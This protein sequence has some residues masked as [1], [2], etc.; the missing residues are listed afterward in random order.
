[1]GKSSESLW[2]EGGLKSK[3]PVVREHTTHA[4]IS[5]TDLLHSNKKRFKIGNYYDQLIRRTDAV[6]N[7]FTEGY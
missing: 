3:R 1:M 5:F 7:K 6:Q 2:G 4:H